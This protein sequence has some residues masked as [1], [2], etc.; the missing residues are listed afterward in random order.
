MFE[1]VEMNNYGDKMEIMGNKK[2]LGESKNVKD[3]YNEN[4][5]EKIWN[6]KG[7]V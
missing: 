3:I 6:E 7:N 4:S 5:M 1:M 2:A